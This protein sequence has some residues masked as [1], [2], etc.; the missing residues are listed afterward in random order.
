MPFEV[1]SFLVLI[2]PQIAIGYHRQFLLLAYFLQEI[3][4]IDQKRTG[5][6]RIV[7]RA[8]TEYLEFLIVRCYL[9]HE[10]C[11]GLLEAK[12]LYASNVLP[13]DVTHMVLEYLRGCDAA[14]PLE[15]HMLLHSRIFDE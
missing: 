8:I 3:V 10:T 5:H 6:K 9:A 14:K 1:K 12:L 11:S 2:I 15:C 7:G 13:V 4:V